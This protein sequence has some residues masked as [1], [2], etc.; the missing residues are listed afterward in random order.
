MKIPTFW[1]KESITGTDRQGQR[2]TFTACGS[3]FS[4]L[5]QARADATARARRIFDLLAN[6]QKPDAYGYLD[7]PI[8]EEIVRD[9]Q[10]EAAGQ[11]LVITRNR[12]GSLVLNAASV[13]FADVDFPPF[14]A[15]GLWERLRWLFSPGRKEEQK[16]ALVEQTMTRVEE[17]RRNNPRHGFRLY[18]THSGLRL[19]FTEKTYEPGSQEVGRILTELGADPVYKKLTEKQKCYRARLTPKPWRC[20]LGRPPV[21]YPWGSRQQEAAQRDWEKE[22]DK[23]TAGFTTCVLLDLSPA[24]GAEPVIRQA[25][26]A[27]D[28]WAC[29]GTAMPL[30]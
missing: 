14:T 5:E 23:K 12:Y 6:G 25:I 19:L 26:E 20:G 28:G 21:S 3:S 13:F 18:R 4:S 30:A 9:L 1:A 7:R 29:Q 11:S 16:L 22:Y 27:H 15:S 2:R 10:A 24:R 17:W 8:R